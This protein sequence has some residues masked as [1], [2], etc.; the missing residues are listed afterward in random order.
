MHYSQV[1]M[2]NKKA[3]IFKTSRPNDNFTVAWSG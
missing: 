2:P 1:L 3:V